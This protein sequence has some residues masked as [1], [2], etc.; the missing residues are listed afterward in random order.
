MSTLHYALDS[1]GFLLLG[2]SEALRHFGDL[3]LSMDRKHKIYH[4][5]GS[6]PLNLELYRTYRS[7]PSTS[8][9]APVAEIPGMWPEL[10]LQ[11]MAD[12]IA[13]A[14]YAPPGFFV[15]ERLNVLQL[16]GQ[17]SAFLEPGPG[18]AT[19]QIQRVIQ[20]R[21]NRWV[22]ADL[23]GKD[24]RVRTVVVPTWSG[25]ASTPGRPLRGSKK[26]NCSGPTARAARLGRA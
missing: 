4:K 19:W 6:V 10:E 1:G 2:L 13:L 16:R 5:T 14:R 20:M 26:A 7:V 21:K 22:I 24:R 15:D 17:V 11:R 9:K 3:F 25:T 12:R 18:A 23:S 8:G